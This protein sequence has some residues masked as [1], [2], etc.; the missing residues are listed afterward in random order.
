MTFTATAETSPAR[1]SGLGTWLQEA[2]RAAY[3]V[4]LL[5]AFW[6]SAVYLTGIKEYLLPPP[7]KVWTGF[8]NAPIP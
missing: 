3:R 8:L 5:F 1:H 2:R 7:S 6:E 4:A